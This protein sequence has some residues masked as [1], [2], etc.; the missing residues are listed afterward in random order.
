MHR[1]Q[2]QI[3]AVPGLD[4]AAQTIIEDRWSLVS[5]TL[6]TWLASADGW[7]DGV[8]NPEH[9]Q[10]LRPLLAAFKAAHATALSKWWRLLHPLAQELGLQAAV[11][12]VQVHTCWKHGWFDYRKKNRKRI[13][14]PPFDTVLTQIQ[15]IPY[16]HAFA[17]E[18]VAAL[19]HQSLCQDEASASMVIARLKQVDRAA[20]EQGWEVVN[21]YAQYGLVGLLKHADYPCTDELLLLQRYAPIINAMTEHPAEVL[22]ALRADLMALYHR[23]FSSQYSARS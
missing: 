7:Y 21:A 5:A 12:R 22:A 3:T 11:E 15:T 13:I 14:R 6:T 18:S 19:L 4:S 8:L 23:P 9:H 10:H 1:E 16:Q 2:R 17:R 20:S